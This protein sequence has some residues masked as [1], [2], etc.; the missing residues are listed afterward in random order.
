MVVGEA[1]AYKQITKRNSPCKNKWEFV[2]RSETISNQWITH[3]RYQVTQTVVVASQL[4]KKFLG[5]FLASNMSLY[6]LSLMIWQALRW[7]E[8]RVGFQY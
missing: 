5:Q 1:V 7:I 6:V 2:R 3:V 4:L 8:S